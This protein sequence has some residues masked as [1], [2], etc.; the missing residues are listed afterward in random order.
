MAVSHL[1]R[2]RRQRRQNLATRNVEVAPREAQRMKVVRLKPQLSLSQVVGTRDKITKTSLLNSKRTAAMKAM[3]RMAWMIRR[4]K[5][6]ASQANA[7]VNV[8]GRE[9]PVE[10]GIFS[11]KKTF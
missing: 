2:S 3:K 6:M 8:S 10:R 9:E 5:L 11:A 7:N 1:F 4:A